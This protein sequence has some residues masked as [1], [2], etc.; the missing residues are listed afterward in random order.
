MSSALENEKGFSKSMSPYNFKIVR[1][2]MIRGSSHI[3]RVL[4]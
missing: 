2:I 4:L 1:K 3:F